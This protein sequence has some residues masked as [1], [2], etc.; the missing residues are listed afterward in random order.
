MKRLL[1]C[2][3]FL[4]LVSLPNFCTAQGGAYSSTGNSIRVDRASHWNKWIYQND[5]V[6]NLNVPV[7]E[8]KILQVDSDGL[9]PKFF[10]GTI[11][12][13]PTAKDF[14]YLDRVRA[15][16]EQ[17]LHKLES[18]P[19]AGP[20]QRRALQ[21]IVARIERRPGIQQVCR[22]GHLLGVGDVGA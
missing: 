16:L 5:L 10:R 21:Q 1:T 11:N 18:A 6:T 2:G 20:S 9:R 19:T 4:L 3:M 7:R 12:G 17:Q 15:A 22:E 8:A 13:A 14:T